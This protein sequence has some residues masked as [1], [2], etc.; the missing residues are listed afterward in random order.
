ML[1]PT[2]ALSRAGISRKADRVKRLEPTVEIRA[3]LMAWYSALTLG[4]EC[5]RGWG[6]AE[7]KLC[8]YLSEN[9]N[10]CVSHESPRK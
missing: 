6:D 5:V 4:V 9:K 10:T 2:A 3:S 7:V 1:T 8:D